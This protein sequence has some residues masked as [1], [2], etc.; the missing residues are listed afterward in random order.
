MVQRLLERI[1]KEKKGKQSTPVRK[2]YLFL[3]FLEEIYNF[4]S[5]SQRNLQT[6][7]FVSKEPT[8]GELSR[9]CMWSLLLDE[10]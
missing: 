2:N 1:E 3:E 4:L 10:D 6:S 5:R 8:S 7:K 9:T